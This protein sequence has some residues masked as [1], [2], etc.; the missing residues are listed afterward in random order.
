[1]R[2]SSNLE[3]EELWASF[4]CCRLPFTHVTTEGLVF[5]A[6][7]SVSSVQVVTILINK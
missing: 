5:I 3:V 1:M 4:L 6:Q 7:D 2:T